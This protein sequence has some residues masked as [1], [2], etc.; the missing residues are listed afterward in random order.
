MFGFSVIARWL[1]ER[2]WVYVEEAVLLV[3][4][5]CYPSSV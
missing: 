5:T 2:S 4:G 3:I 1:E